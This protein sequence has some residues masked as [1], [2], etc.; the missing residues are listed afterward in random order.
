MSQFFQRGYIF[1]FNE[2]NYRD[3]V[4]SVTSARV[5]MEY[6]IF[7]HN[8]LASDSYQLQWQNGSQVVIILTDK[9]T[10]YC[11][12]EPFGQHSR[13]YYRAEHI[14][15]SNAEKRTVTYNYSYLCLFDTTGKDENG[16]DTVEQC[17]SLLNYIKGG[18]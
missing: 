6:G 18:M 15:P 13:C 12:D 7:A 2:F 16:A 11:V 3:F 1:F 4:E 14:N 8:Q 17:D 9:V 10:E 5:I